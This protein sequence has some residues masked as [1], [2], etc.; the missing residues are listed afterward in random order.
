MNGYDMLNDE[1]FRYVTS[2]PFTPMK[3][4]NRTKCDLCKEIIGSVYHEQ[5]CKFCAS[6]HKIV[7]NMM[8]KWLIDRLRNYNACAITAAADNRLPN[9]KTPD[10]ELTIKNSTYLLDVGFSAR[11]ETY[12]KEK[13]AKY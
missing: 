13:I 3:P 10:I 4:I 1:A 12:Y 2:I 6:E 11:P 8:Q 7:H 5:D 9:G